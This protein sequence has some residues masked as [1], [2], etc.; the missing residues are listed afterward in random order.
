MADEGVLFEGLRLGS[1]QAFALLLDE[2]DPPMRRL[3]RLY[4]PEE[5]V[6]P[7][8]RQ[9]WSTAL[10]GLDM[11]TWHTT[12]R[13]WVSGIF[14]TYGRAWRTAAPD[15]VPAVAPAPPPAPRGDDPGT[16]VE[17]PWGSLGWSGLWAD[18]DWR[19]LEGVMSSQPLAVREVLWLRD[20]EGWSWRE[21]LDALGLTAAQGEQLLVRGREEL[22]AWVA[23]HVGAG[24]DPDGQGRERTDGVATLLGAL[25]PVH[26]GRATDAELQRSFTAWRRHR[27]VRP[28]RRWHWE[29]RTATRT[30]PPAADVPAPGAASRGG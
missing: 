26:A 19:L 20:V 4:V 13:A 28:W 3:A 7:L 9:T 29:L 24:P 15:A 25:R 14:V 23:A 27:G 18:D 2:Y 10:P 17:V 8:V 11:F 6:G 1:A 5:Q 22:A 30:R 16:D 12:L 21:V